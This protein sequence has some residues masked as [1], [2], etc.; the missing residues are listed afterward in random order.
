MASQRAN[1]EI[2]ISRKKSNERKLVS[3]CVDS[4]TQLEFQLE[5]QTFDV[6]QRSKIVAFHRVI[7]SHFLRVTR[8]N[9]SPQGQPKANQP[10]LYMTASRPRLELLLFANSNFNCS[11]LEYLNRAVA[12][13]ATLNGRLSVGWFGGPPLKVIFWPRNILQTTLDMQPEPW[14]TKKSPVIHTE[15]D[16]DNEIGPFLSSDN[17][18]MIKCWNKRWIFA[19]SCEALKVVLTSCAKHV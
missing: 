5:F 2:C 4:T 13:T 14:R 10:T 12:T 7:N 19:R 1:P 3:S 9:V 17:W 15:D 6:L 16:D 18:G 8:S 11:K